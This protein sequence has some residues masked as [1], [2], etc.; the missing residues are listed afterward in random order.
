M[1]IVYYGM[2]LFSMIV[3]WTYYVQHAVI[4]YLIV[5]LSLPAKPRHASF[6]TY[7]IYVIWV[8]A[9]VQATAKVV[10]CYVL[11]FSAH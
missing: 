3:I 5:H 8:A 7:F 1:Y 10:K 9:M 6:V 2:N 4:L 11:F